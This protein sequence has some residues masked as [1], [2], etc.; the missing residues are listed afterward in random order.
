L[1]TTFALAWRRA[2]PEDAPLAWLCAIGVA[3]GLALVPFAPLLARFA[4]ACV[5][6]TMTGVPC[7][8]CG[9]TR[10]VLALAALD[11]PRALSWNPLVTVA[12]VGIAAAG[13]A[14]PAW[15]AA[16]GP[17]PLGDEAACR[18]L[19][20]LAPAALLANWLYL[21]LRGV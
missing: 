12:L 6:H 14:A 13:F 1:S 8:T 2:R 11:V 15:V 18:W 19:R 9:S 16:R 3:S 7:P 17:L 10:A 5:L 4:P 21:V 20:I